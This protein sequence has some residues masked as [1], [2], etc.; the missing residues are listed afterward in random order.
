MGAFNEAVKAIK[1]AEDAQKDVN[2]TIQLL[3]DVV[4]K[5]NEFNK[6]VDAEFCRLDSNGWR[7]NALNSQEGNTNGKSIDSYEERYHELVNRLEEDKRERI[8]NTRNLVA[9][10]VTTGIALVITITLILL[11][12]FHVI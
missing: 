1:K 9:C 11:I 4:E 6:K 10:W 5:T 12:V 7:E 2:N 8:R 3:N